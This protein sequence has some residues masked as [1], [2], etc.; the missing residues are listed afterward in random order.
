MTLA[1]SLNLTNNTQVEFDRW[2][3]DFVLRVDS[4]TTVACSIVRFWRKSPNY[5]P[6]RFSKMI[7]PGPIQKSLKSYDHL[8][9]ESVI[10]G[11][12]SSSDRMQITDDWKQTMVANSKLKGQRTNI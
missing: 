8:V 9:C 5:L 2:R 11:E 7:N 4:F 6:R 1:R 10:V 3:V 12:E